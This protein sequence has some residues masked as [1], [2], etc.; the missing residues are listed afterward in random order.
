MSQL[1]C[2]RVKEEGVGN[3]DPQ[4]SGQEVSSKDI[5]NILMWSNF[6]NL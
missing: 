6:F 3:V 1:W 4:I 2:Q 5:E